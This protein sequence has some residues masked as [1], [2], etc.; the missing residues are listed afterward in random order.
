MTLPRGGFSH[1]ERVIENLHISPASQVADFGSGS[2]YFTL[3]LARAVGP[4]GA[5]FAIDVL[6]SALQV[7]SARS[8]DEGLFNVRT[9]RADLETAKGSTLPD[10]SQDMVLCAN[11]LFQ[12]QKKADILAEAHRVVKPGGRMVMIDWLPNTPFGPKE[13]G[14]KFSAE[15]GRELGEQ[16]GFLFE[17]EIHPSTNHWGIVFRK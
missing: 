12:S 9:L 8:R 13:K 5:V 10:N 11:I 3:H 14:W 6:S 1:P 16:A 15:E 17:Q 4:D 2:G 7:I